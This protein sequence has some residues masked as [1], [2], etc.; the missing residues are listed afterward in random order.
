MTQPM[1]INTEFRQP[2]SQPRHFAGHMISADFRG[3]KVSFKGDAQSLLND[4]AEE[5]SFQFSEKV[6]KK[7]SKRNVET[8]AGRRTSALERAEFYLKKLPDLKDGRKLKQ[9]LKMLKKGGKQSPKQL[10]EQAREFFGDVSHRFAGLAYARDMVRTEGMDPDLYNA[11]ETAVDQSLEEEGP[12]IRAGL[13]VTVTAKA[14]SE[15]GL[16]EIQELRDFYRNTV[17]QYDGFEATY[18][19]VADNFPETDFQEAAGF[20]L[21][22][23]GQD[24]HARGPSISTVELK[25]IIDDLYQLEVLVQIHGRCSDLLAKINTLYGILAQMRA[26]GFLRRLLE[27]KREAWLRSD[28]VLAFVG[29][30]GAGI[31]E[32]RIYILRE[33]MKMIRELPFKVFADDSERERMLDAFQEAQDLEIESEEEA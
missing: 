11:L 14:F 15:K 8:R 19:S 22:A 20:L 10:R 6:E 28:R 31:A 21:Q 2:L 30:T 12:Q 9:F 16:A 13:N 18:N 17:L 1:D 24:L 25:R 33:T 32:A 29:E 7:L 4:A 23:L 27:L 3:Q 26:G 5:I